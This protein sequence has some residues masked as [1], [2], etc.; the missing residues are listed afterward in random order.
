MPQAKIKPSDIAAEAKRLY[1]PH[2]TTSCPQFPARSI[3]FSDT[4]SLKGEPR[5]GCEK[6]RVAVI[7]GD[8]VDVALDW[9]DANCKDS[10]A[11]STSRSSVAGSSIPVVNMANERR[12]G[13]DWE[14]GLI[15][16]EECLCRRSTLAQALMT[17]C[18]SSPKTPHYPIRT[19]GGIY[20]PSVG[21]SK[22]FLNIFLKP[23]FC[24]DLKAGC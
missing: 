10:A 8:P 22:L 6:L 18:T 20:S 12:P 14:S 21:E 9:H 4:S 3:S 2:V 11:G 13:G 1:I 15:A 23:S 17:P 19:A 7:D 5:T 16:P 24:P